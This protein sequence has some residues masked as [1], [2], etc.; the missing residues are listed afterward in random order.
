MRHTNQLNKTIPVKSEVPTADYR[1]YCVLRCD[2]CSLL[3]MFQH[4]E[5][6]DASI[7][8]EKE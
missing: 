6:P 5:E 2:S 8:R 4:L 7:F 1:D 3:D